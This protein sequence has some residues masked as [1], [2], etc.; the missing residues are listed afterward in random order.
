MTLLEPEKQNNF[1][2]KDVKQALQVGVS[3]NK[4]LKSCTYKAC[5]Q[6]I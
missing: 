5:K 2:L 6:A 1:S 3:A 4:I